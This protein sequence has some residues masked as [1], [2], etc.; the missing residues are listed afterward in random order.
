MDKHRMETIYVAWDNTSTYQDDEVE[1][2]V[3]AAGGRL[4]LLYLP[5]LQ[6]L[7]KSG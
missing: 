1:A 7:A 4:V 5:P 6:S 2:V 3:R